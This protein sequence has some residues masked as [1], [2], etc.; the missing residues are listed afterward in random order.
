VGPVRNLPHDPLGSMTEYRLFLSFAD[1]EWHERPPANVFPHSVTGIG[2]AVA[3][4][5]VYQ[6]GTGR[7]NDRY[8]YRLPGK[9]AL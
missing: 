8:L 9:E 7:R 5:L 2:R 3:Q 4:D 6:S 1:R